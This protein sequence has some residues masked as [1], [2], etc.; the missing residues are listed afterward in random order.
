M[1]SDQPGPSKR[2]V[3]RRVIEAPHVS[4]WLASR[5]MNVGL[6]TR[7]YFPDEAALNDADLVLA[8]VGSPRLDTLVTWREDW[9]GTPTHLFDI[10][11]QGPRE[12][13]FLDT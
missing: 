8:I 3:N 9:D 11:L 1:I 5:G 4:L 6:S 7:M 10:H 13:V 12:T 2:H